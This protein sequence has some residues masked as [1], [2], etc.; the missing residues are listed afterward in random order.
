MRA[1]N[2][3]ASAIRAINRGN[4]V[5]GIPEDSGAIP[6]VVSR[7]VIGLLSTPR[8]SGGVVRGRTC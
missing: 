4:G 3:V 5:L 7:A 8:K 2:S 1:G 6:G